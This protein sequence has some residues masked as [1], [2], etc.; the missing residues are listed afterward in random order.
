MITQNRAKEIKP[1]TIPLT[2]EIAKH[3]DRMATLKG[4]RDPDTLKGQKRIAWLHGLLI[5]GMFHSPEWSDI[6]ILTKKK[7]AKPLTFRM[8]GGHSSRMLVHAGIYFPENMYVTLRHFE[9]DSRDA[10]IDLYEQFNQRRSTRTRIDLI[11][12]RIAYISKLEEVSP[13]TTASIISGIVYHF[14]LRDPNEEYYE[15]DMIHHYSEF[16]AWSAEFAIQRK[17][18]RIGVVGAMLN[19]YIS[20]SV[21]ALEF[22][23]MVRDGT[24][25]TPDCPTRVLNDFLNECV[26]TKG[27]LKNSDVKWDKRAF[28]VK[29]H[30]AW[31]A[32]RKG[33][34]TDLKYFKGAPLPDLSN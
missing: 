8:D 25:Q 31:N 6:K 10:A 1:E 12:N 19:T 30:H 20:N 17:L 33:G 14:K 32:W 5:D 2:L 22:W 15:L 28:Y 34:K 26:F 24:G 29:C 18:N 4:D 7:K 16:I 23:R 27:R 11:K 21:K 9:T 3:Y 13:T